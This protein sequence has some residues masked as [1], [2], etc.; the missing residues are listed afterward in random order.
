MRRFICIL[1]IMIVGLS[2]EAQE[3]RLS[4]EYGYK[5]NKK[6]HLDFSAEVRKLYGNETNHFLYFKADYSYKINKKYRFRVG[7]RYSFEAG[8]FDNNKYRLT[9]DFIQKPKYKLGNSKVKNRVRLQYAI[10][11]WER[12]VVVL[13]DQLKMTYDI[14]KYASPYVSLEVLY[15][16]NK[17]DPYELRVGFGTNLD[18]SDV[19]LDLYYRTEIQEGYK[20]ILFNH[21]I[22][23][24][25][26]F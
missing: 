16:T 3:F 11:D 23:M 2:M 8:D 12:S 1:V 14:N 15:I 20:T 4:G 5:I 9:F 6:N 24:A 10:N 22:G 21:V 26:G 17:E 18:V 19:K 13:R 7:N 25:W